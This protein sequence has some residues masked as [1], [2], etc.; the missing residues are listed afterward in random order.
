MVTVEVVHIPSLH[1]I[2]TQV[3]EGRKNEHLAALLPVEFKPRG[4]DT[5]PFRSSLILFL[6]NLAECFLRAFINECSHAF[7]SP[8]RQQFH[9]PI[10]IH[11]RV[12]AIHCPVADKDHHQIH[13]KGR[14]NEHEWK[15]QQAVK[16]REES[17]AK[18]SLGACKHIEA[19]SPQLLNLQCSLRVARRLHVKEHG[20]LVHQEGHFVGCVPVVECEIQGVRQGLAR[21]CSGTP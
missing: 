13:R 14:R 16:A 20:F 3:Q 21:N 11:L 8:R 6:Q 1:L 4:A 10:A 9:L 17:S 15:E 7:T 5:R 18:H 12:M 2:S 19:C